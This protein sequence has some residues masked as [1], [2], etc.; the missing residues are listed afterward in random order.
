MMG[1]PEIDAVHA[2][3]GL[4]PVKRSLRRQDS[5]GFQPVRATI[6]GSNF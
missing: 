4:A 6:P 1:N 3:D 5:S 2:G